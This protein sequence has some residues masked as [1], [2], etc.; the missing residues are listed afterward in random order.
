MRSYV[1]SKVEGSRFRVEAVGSRGDAGL[2]YCS[3]VGYLLETSTTINRK[4]A[5]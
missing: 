3:Y 1:G 5:S 2:E 4:F